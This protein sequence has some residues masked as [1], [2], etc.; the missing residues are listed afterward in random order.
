MHCMNFNCQIFSLMKLLE[1]VLNIIGVVGGWSGCTC[2]PR[3]EKKFFSRNLQGKLVSAPPAHQVH[4]QAEQESIFR[5]FLE[6]WR[7]QWF[8]Y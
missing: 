1:T 6:I 5:T 8:I 2:T 3:A 4:P 7:W